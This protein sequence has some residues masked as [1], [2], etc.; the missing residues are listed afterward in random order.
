MYGRVRVY[1]GPGISLPLA[2]AFHRYRLPEVDA[3]LADVVEEVQA[4]A[5]AAVE[6][7]QMVEKRSLAAG[8]AMT[9]ADVAVVAASAAAKT[10]SSG[11]AVYHSLAKYGSIRLLMDQVRVCIPAAGF[12]ESAL[13]VRLVFPVLLSHM[14]EGL[15]HSFALAF[16]SRVHAC[17]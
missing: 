1:F 14:P 3:V 2:H 6:A 12:D 9:P 11:S 5:L 13:L 4:V 10:S 16:S 8:A 15:L 7:V 17:I